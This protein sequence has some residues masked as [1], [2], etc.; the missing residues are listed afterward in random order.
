MQFPYNDISAEIGDNFVVA[1]LR[2]KNLRHVLHHIAKIFP[3]LFN[4]LRRIEFQFVTDWGNLSKE[5]CIIKGFFKF[6][7]A[8]QKLKWHFKTKTDFTRAELKFSP[9][10]F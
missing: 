5:N 7:S 10:K 2:K 1:F 9:E 4:L 3:I 6:K 8:K